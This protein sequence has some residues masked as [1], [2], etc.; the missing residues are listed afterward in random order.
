[1]AEHGLGPSYY[2]IRHHSAYA[3]HKM[4]I[5]TKQWSGSLGDNGQ[6]G[7]ENWASGTV[8]AVD[9]VEAL[10]DA[11]TPKFPS[12]V[13]FDTWQIFNFN[14]GA[15]LYLPVAAGTFTGKMGSDADPGWTEAVQSIFTMWDEEFNTVKLELLDTSSRNNFARRTPA[16]ADDDELGIFSEFSDTGNAW[17]SRAGFRPATLRSIS[18]GINDEL[19][20]QYPTI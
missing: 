3:P 13:H 1:M 19:K 4:T 7:F 5:C 17:A 18:L 2:E 15:G 8:D 9:M 12:T 10:V 16:T 11:L 6:G 20:K 14:E